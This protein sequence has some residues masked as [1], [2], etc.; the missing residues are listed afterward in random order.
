MIFELCARRDVA[1]NHT[2]RGDPQGSV[3]R[4]SRLHVRSV[5]LPQWKAHAELRVELC[6]FVQANEFVVSPGARARI[7]GNAVLMPRR[8]SLDNA[9]TLL[10]LDDARPPGTRAFSRPHRRKLALGLCDGQM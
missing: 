4:C 2:D 7:E 8:A 3:V 6:E 1:P 5:V 9:P 10:G